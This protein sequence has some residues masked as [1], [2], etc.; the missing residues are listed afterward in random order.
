MADNLGAHVDE[1]YELRE[2]KRRKTQEIKDIEAKME[3][4]DAD[5][6]TRMSELGVTLIR[7]TKASI[8]LS[9]ST[10][11]MMQDFDKFMKYVKEN[12]ADYLLQRRI[13]SAPW[14]ELVES[15]ETVPGIEPMDRET[16]SV[17]KI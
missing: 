10:I 4:L 3:T 13:N 12:D 2:A 14:R 1:L 9:H 17:R 5:I 8:S 7:G 6:K 11:P 15:G 16:L